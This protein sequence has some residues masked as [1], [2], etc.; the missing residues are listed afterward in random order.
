MHNIDLVKY[1]RGVS[2][3]VP[4]ESQLIGA[5]TEHSRNL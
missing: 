1:K 5:M 4:D 3:G 2:P